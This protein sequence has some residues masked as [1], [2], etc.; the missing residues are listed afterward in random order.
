MKRALIIPSLRGGGHL[1]RCRALASELTRRGFGCTMTS[2]APLSASSYDVSVV[3]MEGEEHEHDVYEALRGRPVV[4]VID[5]PHAVQARAV[6]CATVGVSP[7]VFPTATESRILL[8]GSKFA[9][10]RPEFREMRSDAWKLSS[11]VGSVADAN[12]LSASEMATV[13]LRHGRLHTY[14]GVRALEAACV[15]SSAVGLD[16]VARNAAE[17]MNRA[18]LC[19]DPAAD[20]VDGLGCVRVADYIEAML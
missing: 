6:V 2:K 3:D 16:I 11:S 5:T 13:M 12:G 14:G 4:A 19:A 10:L 18:G 8:C 17:E 1:V 20:L 7:D 15:R 9:L